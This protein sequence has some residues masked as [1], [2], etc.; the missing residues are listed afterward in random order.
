MIE[1]DS[2]LVT[3]SNKISLKFTGIFNQTRV[4]YKINLFVI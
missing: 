1:Y 4:N 2:I 3:Y